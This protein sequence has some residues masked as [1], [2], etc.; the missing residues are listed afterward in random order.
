MAHCA[1]VINAGSRDEHPDQ[2]GLAHLT[3]HAFFK[4]TQRRRAWQV[5]CRLENLGGELNAFT[6]KEDTTIHATTLRGD[7]PRAAEL[8]A[9]VAFRSTFPERELER[10][11]EVIADEINTYK[12]SPADLIYDTFEDML[13]AGSELGHNILGRKNALARY[14]GEAIRAFTGR[15]HTTDQM[16]FSSIGNF[17]AKTADILLGAAV[18][19]LAIFFYY[20][21]FLLWISAKV[22]GVNISLIQLFLMRIRKVP[23]YIITRAMIEAHK[24]G[25]KTLTR[26][27][28]EAHYLAGGHVEKVVHALVSASKA[29]IDL[30]FQMATAID[31]AGRDVFE[32]VQMSVNP[33][34]ID[35]P[36]VTAVAKDGIQLIAKARVTVR[37]NIKQLVGGAGEET[38]LARVGEGIVSSIGSS[39]SH[40]TVLE[41]PDSISK[42]VLRKGLDAGTA[43]E[44]LSIDIADIDIGKNIGAFLQ[45]DQAQADKN[46][47]QAKAEERRAMAV[48]LEHFQN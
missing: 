39:E 42:L 9:D 12:D 43:F 24:A 2:Y 14:D 48:A 41:N 11:K 10:E 37:A 34:V 5:N 8:I 44:I 38:I 22:S 20:V 25:I 30:P 23:P 36:P 4:G 28:L 33:K 6:T 47:A 21:P 15:T 1:L 18:L 17:S 26:D 46:I 3:E 29:N 31:L 19:L 45:M 16:V 40:K 32:A 35:T 13:F 27:E 7:F